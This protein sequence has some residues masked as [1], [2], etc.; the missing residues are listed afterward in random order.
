MSPHAFIK[1]NQDELLQNLR[2]LIAFETVNPPGAEYDGIT[3]HLEASLKG[4]GLKARRLT[5]SLKLQKKLNPDAARFPRHNVIGLWKVPGAR[6]TLHFNAHYDV[7]PVGGQWKHGN[8]FSGALERGWIYGRGSAD[9]KGS[10]ASLFLALK[11]LKTSGIQPK[12]NVEVSFTADEETDSLLGSGW[13]VEHAP[14]SPDYALVMEGGD[15]TEVCCGHNG[16]VWLEVEV[17]GKAAH[18]SRPSHGIN[19]LEKMAALVLSLDE[20]KRELAQ[21]EF[22]APDGARMFPTMNLG[23][24]FEQGPGGKINTVPALAR[25][26]IDRRVIASETVEAAERELRSTLAK[27][28]AAIPQCRIRIRKV[29]DNHP[30]YTPPESPFFA[31]MAGSVERIRRKPA[32]FVV[33]TGFTDMHFF[34]Q[35]LRIPTLGYGPGG[36]NEHG[37]DERAPVSDL[38]RTAQVYADLLTSF[39]G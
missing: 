19:A 14:I 23:G 36:L 16:V 25:F 17:L 11:A 35:H 33:S 3:K 1:A 29:S 4:L 22:V 6:R 30:C 8:P 37:V 24:V 15:G 7:V 5:P 2:K 20:H 12:L 34:A 27:A 21:R 18:G 28:A 32:S 9:M 39:E 31:A 38:L 26:S 13:L 10:I